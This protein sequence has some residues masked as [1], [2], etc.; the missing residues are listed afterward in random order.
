MSIMNTFPFAFGIFSKGR[1]KKR[2][3][4]RFKD[5][6][7]DLF[8]LAEAGF[9]EKLRIKK[10]VFRQDFLNDFIS[11]GKA[12]TNAVRAR[13]AELFVRPDATMEAFLYPEAA[14]NLYLPVKIG[15][16]TDFYSS[17][18]HA[19]NVGVMF[20]DPSKALLP[21]WKHLPVAYHG[22]ASSI[23][24]S[25]TNFHRPK[26]QINA[27]DET[28]PVFSASKRV[29]IELE[30]ATI[31]GK[32][33]PIG[34]AIDVNQAEEYVFGFALFN[35]WSARDIQRWEYV[36]LGPFLAKNFM[37]SMA[38]WVIPIEELEEFR[39]PAEVQNPVVLPYLQENKRRNFDVQLDVYLQTFNGEKVKIASSNFK[40]M[41]WTVAQ[42]IAHHTINGCNLNV[43]DVLASGT[44]SGKTQDSFGSLLEL[45]WGGKNP[46]QLPDGSTRSFLE[47]GD[48]I[49][50]EGF[51]EKDGVRV[52]FGEV[53]GTVLPA[54]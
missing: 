44:I 26:G 38:P 8:A 30:M 23:V 37:S 39:V 29:D 28:P 18:Q 6:V 21:N 14:V 1:Q 42:Q 22:R 25:G 47:D 46:I 45:S 4:A 20:R 5:Q 11:L 13:L 15:D 43:G 50:I 27:S 17:E 10:T 40:N 32:G 31:I 54:L 52:D 2:L 35:D 48:T 34:E 3:A 19:Y 16:Y 36:P 41:Y 49:I 51:A 9:F 53:R 24:V 7:I 33:N 12:K